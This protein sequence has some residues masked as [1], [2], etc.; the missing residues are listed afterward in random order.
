MRTPQIDAYLSHILDRNARDDAAPG[1]RVT[2]VGR[3]GESGQPPGDAVAVDGRFIRILDRSQRERDLAPVVAKLQV[4]QR[5]LI[6]TAFRPLADKLAKPPPHQSAGASR[7]PVIHQFRVA[8]NRSLLHAHQHERIS[9]GDFLHQ[10]LAAFHPR[11]NARHVRQFRQRFAVA[12]SLGEFLGF[13][14]VSGGQVRQ[15]LRPLLDGGL[16]LVAVG[17]RHAD[18]HVPRVQVILFGHVTR[19]DLVDQARDCR[20]QI[21]RLI[22]VL[23][24]RVQP[25]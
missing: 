10:R 22:R 9:L 12:L 7:R 1:G 24:A 11:P 5:R 3:I 13:V 20:C 4:P 16:L 6:A 17:V 18:Q 19:H 15:L 8:A 14:A 21:G 2:W 23:V 25:E